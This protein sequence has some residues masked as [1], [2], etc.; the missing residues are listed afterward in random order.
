MKNIKKFY[1]RLIPPSNLFMSKL[2]HL[3]ISMEKFKQILTSKKF[4]TLVAAVVAALSA[5]FATSC[6]GAYYM[7]R[8]GVHHDTVYIE[9]CVK[10]KASPFD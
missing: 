9:E 3:V 8:H 10:S 4:W 1:K 2:F 7:Q 5:Y 6:S